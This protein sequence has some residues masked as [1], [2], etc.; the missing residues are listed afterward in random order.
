MMDEEKKYTG[1]GGYH[2]GGRKKMDPAVKKQFK[3]ASIS[4]TPEEMDAL[5]A[6]AKAEGLTLSRY[7]ITKLL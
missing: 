5:K 4:G 6:K 3:T 1:R 7:V 2:G